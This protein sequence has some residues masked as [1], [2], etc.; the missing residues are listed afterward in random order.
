MFQR[1]KSKDSLTKKWTSRKERMFCV[2]VGIHKA[3]YERLMIIL[4]ALTMDE[5]S[6]SFLKGSCTLVKFISP[7]TRKAL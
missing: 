2:I 7:A 6:P 3:T 4:K 1:K 5:I